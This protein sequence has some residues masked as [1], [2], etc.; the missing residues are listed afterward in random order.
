MMEDEKQNVRK[1]LTEIKRCVAPERLSLFKKFI[2]HLCRIQEPYNTEYPFIDNIIHGIE[3]A[4]ICITKKP[5]N[6]T[7]RF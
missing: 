5:D 6:I 3:V 1:F 2:G 4:R 7:C